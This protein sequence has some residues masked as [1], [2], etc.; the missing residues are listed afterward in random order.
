MDTNGRRDQ[1]VGLS[2]R[3]QAL[4]DVP[5]L[6]KFHRG[7]KI[8][9]RDVLSG[10]ALKLIPFVEEE[11]VSAVRKE[12][13]AMLPGAIEEFVGPLHKYTMPDGTVYIEKV[14]AEIESFGPMYFIALCRP[15]G[16]WVEET[17]WTKE[18]LDDFQ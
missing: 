8:Y 17:R 13:Y 3:A 6:T 5:T 1:Y 11:T 10:E 7:W 9:E 18:E 12:R 15:D 14:Q 4:L 16:S 2:D